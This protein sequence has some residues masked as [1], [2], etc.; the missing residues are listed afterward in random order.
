MS[1]I[2]DTGRYGSA[3]S[4][5]TYERVSRYSPARLDI[6]G[7]MEALAHVDSRTDE[8]RA[9]DKESAATLR[10]ARNQQ[11]GRRRPAPSF[12]TAPLPRYNRS[13][14][15]GTSNRD[16]RGNT[17][18]RYRRKVFLLTKFGDGET[19]A[20]YRCGCELDIRT[21]TADR[22]IPKRNGGRY[23]RDN[24]RPACGSCNSETGGMLATETG[25][26]RLAEE[27]AER[28]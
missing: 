5:A 13:K 4:Y 2:G 27:E 10:A 11:E 17:T 7:I 8:Q 9:Q 24:I 19:C 18:D 1:F 20:C 12:S 16:D 23:T 14:P 25:R 22:I 6:A 15:R 21:V 3:S 26:R 28:G